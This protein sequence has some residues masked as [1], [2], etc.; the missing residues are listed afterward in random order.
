MSYYILTSGSLDENG[1]FIPE[2]LILSND[3]ILGPQQISTLN[4]Q[5]G[6]I[7]HNILNTISSI[8]ND[9]NDEENVTTE[10]F[11]TIEKNYKQIECPICL[12][13][14]RDNL[15][16]N[17]NHKFCNSCLYK[18]IKVENKKTCPSCRDKIF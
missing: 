10:Q 18:W 7:Y 4:T 3:S 16:L 12:N 11:M 6:E 17:C 15:I 8:L 13:K 1:N 2:E 14:T 5:I 9:N